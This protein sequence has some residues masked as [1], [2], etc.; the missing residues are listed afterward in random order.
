MK[1]NQE[2][3]T[4]TFQCRNG[5]AGLYHE[6]EDVHRIQE[7][8]H[9]NRGIFVSESEVIDFWHHRSQE[10]DS[11]W[12]SVPY[13][14][15]VEI[16]EWFDNFIKFIGVETDEEKEEYS[17]PPPRVGV[18]V[19]VK[20][21]EGQPWEIEMDPHYHAQLISDIESQIPEKSEGGSIRYSLEYD[22]SK[23]WNMRKLEACKTPREDGIIEL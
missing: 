23:I 20:D 8:L 17:E 19:V 13:H 22:S 12:L 9:R 6:L 4:Q 14:D 16:L 3:V 21:A 1:I 5:T 11:S 18:K 10:W 7:V 15:D 2:L